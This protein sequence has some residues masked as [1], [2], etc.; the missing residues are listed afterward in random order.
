[1]GC[2]SG[3]D[4][5]TVS[6]GTSETPVHHVRVNNFYIGKYEVTQG[7]WKKVMGDLPA[8]L[9]N[10]SSYLGDDKA[11]DCMSW[12]DIV[13]T[14]TTEGFLTRLNAQTGKNYRLPT[15]AEWEYAARGCRG[16]VCESFEYS[17]SDVAGDVAWHYIS[18]SNPGA[19]QLVGGK[20]ANGLDL[21]DMSGNVREH[22]S[23]WYSDSCYYS[24]SYTASN[25]QDNPTGPSSGSMR[26][27]RGGGFHATPSP[28]ANR[29]AGRHRIPP[30]G[31]YG[32]IGFRLVME[33]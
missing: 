17:G 11:V 22:C 1:M 3:R 18:S 8:L 6:C 16:R 9:K 32:D 13:G 28:V 27:T 4:D 26:V 5:K 12:D 33:P 29:V 30:T 25:P 7:L 19:P 21:Y 10:N 31:R 2:K 23:D 20:R 15:E 24:S 14:D